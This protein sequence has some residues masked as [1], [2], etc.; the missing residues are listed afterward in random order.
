MKNLS[1]IYSLLIVFVLLSCSKTKFTCEKEIYL[2]KP[3]VNRF[4]LDDRDSIAVKGFTRCEALEVRIG[5]LPE[6]I[7]KESGYDKS[8]HYCTYEAMVEM[9]DDMEKLVSFREDTNLGYSTGDFEDRGF[10]QSTYL[11]E[12]HKYLKTYTYL[13]HIF[14]DEKGQDADIWYPRSPF[15]LEWAF[16]SIDE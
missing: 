6:N 15:Y 14:K 11:K 13:V 7:V 5:T 10:M 1:F 3:E 12:G 4:T 16:F 9:E 2:S 8:Y